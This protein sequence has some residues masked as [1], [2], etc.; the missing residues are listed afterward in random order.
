MLQ[1]KMTDN[2]YPPIKETV[3]RFVT[4]VTN[5]DYACLD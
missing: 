1:A 2:I 4:Y 3:P 5:S